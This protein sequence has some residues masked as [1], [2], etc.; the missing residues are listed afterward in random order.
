MKLFFRKR[1]RGKRDHQPS[2][3]ATLTGAELEQAIVRPLPVYLVASRGRAP[4]DP[5]ALGVGRSAIPHP[6]WRSL[7]DRPH[8][9]GGNRRMGRARAARRG[10][11]SREGDPPPP[12]GPRR[13]E[14]QPAA[15]F[16]PSAG[17]RFF[18]AWCIWPPRTELPEQPAAESS[19]L[20]R[21][22]GNPG[23]RRDVRS[24][25]P[26][27]AASRVDDPTVEAWSR[28]RPFSGNFTT[29]PYLLPIWFPAIEQPTESPNCFASWWTPPRCFRPPPQGARS[30]WPR[31]PPRCSA[32]LQ[33]ARTISRPPRRGFASAS[34]RRRESLER[35]ADRAA[36]RGNLVRDD[37]EAPALG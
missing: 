37:L 9:A 29:S 1:R 34:C 26:R 25:P 12:A 36:V 32:E 13:V 24:P 30:R 15:R 5:P 23:I 6:A 10:S 7:R 28:R 14:G 16:S 4:R 17:G 2:A 3:S 18:T 27:E 19:L 21:S 35:R 11:N 8:F 33:P 31:L 22:S 20:D